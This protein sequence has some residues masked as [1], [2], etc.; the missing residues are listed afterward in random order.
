[1]IR[2]EKLENSMKKLL[3]YFSKMDNLKMSKNENL[4]KSFYI[5][6]FL[7]LRNPD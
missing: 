6:F 2:N 1:M 4:R 3:K 5:P 7:T